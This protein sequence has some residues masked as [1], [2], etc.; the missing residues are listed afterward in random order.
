[1]KKLDLVLLEGQ[2]HRVLSIKEDK[3]LVI[4]CIKSSMPF[5]TRKSYLEEK[6]NLT[7]E[8]VV[9]KLWFLRTNDFC[10][11]CYQKTNISAAFS[12]QIEIDL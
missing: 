11:G 6:E 12:L 3:C 1:M 9:S 5:W 2:L 10:A 7:L 4:N 8:T